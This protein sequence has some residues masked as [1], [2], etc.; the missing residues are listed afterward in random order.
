MNLILRFLMIAALACIGVSGLS[1]AQSVGAVK[2]EEIPP[3]VK[4]NTD[5]FSGQYLIGSGDVLDIRVY[6]RPQ[7]SR[8]TV[9]V[10]GRGMI[11]MPLIEE[12]IR[13][14]CRT[15]SSLAEEISSLYREYLRYPHVEVFI[16]DFQSKPAVV[17]GAIR[18]PGRFQMQRQIRLLELLS[19]AGG[20][21]EQAGGRIQ[22]RHDRSVKRCKSMGIQPLPNS[23]NGSVEWY[24][25]KDLLSTDK[26]DDK[27]NPV[28]LP[29][30]VVN[31]IEADKIYVIGNVFKPMTIALKE[32]VTLT[33]ALAMAGGVMQD[34]DLD[35]ISV[36]RRSANGNSKVELIV[37]LKA[38]NK[39]KA[40]DIV[41]KPND[42][43]EVRSSRAKRFMRGLLESVAPGIFRLPVRIIP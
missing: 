23:P 20:P 22:I 39:K 7:L 28:I 5:D 4:D 16:K 11:R 17:I 19:F 29:G 40:E 24:E 10:D 35:K 38:I 21:T 8:E 42:I 43:V 1:F 2:A 27:N 26:Y 15:D 6:N 33:Q 30:D 34:T 9:R 41:L 18:E 14:A 31:L 32:P 13:A 3:P 25:L 36:S 37:D 12:P